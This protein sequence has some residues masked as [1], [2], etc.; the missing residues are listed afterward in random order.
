MEFHFKVN[1][2][3]SIE[4]SEQLTTDSLETTG[5][6]LMTEHF[7]LKVGLLTFELLFHVGNVSRQ[8]RKANL[9]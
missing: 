4:L 2:D 6:C 9:P 8:L 7:R 1:R 5:C 3:S